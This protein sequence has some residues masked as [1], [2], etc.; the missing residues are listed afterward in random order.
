MS[1]GQHAESTNA[2]RLSMPDPANYGGRSSTE[3]V[4]AWT[5]DP[6]PAPEYPLEETAASNTVPA[7]NAT[8]TVS[9]QP[10]TATAV[11]VPTHSGPK[12]ANDDEYRY[13][14]VVPQ[15]SKLAQS[16]RR[17]NRWR[18]VLRVVALIASV[19]AFGFILGATPY[20]KRS[21]PFNNPAMVYFSYFVGAFSILVSLAFIVHSAA[22]S[23][24]RVNKIPR[25]GQIGIDTLMTLLWV[26]V[27]IVQLAKFPCPIGGHNGWCDFYN[28]SIF[29]SLL[30]M[31]IFA[32]MLGWD[33][34]GSVILA[35][36][37]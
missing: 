16:W 34:I 2:W 13:D 10:A 26:I 33:I 21:I 25:F 7:V 3:H 32:V 27:A 6:A 31:V 29:F 17:P 22:R 18:F 37:K 8:P 12:P 24:S 9:S 1:T 28:T 20:S 36:K 5:A 35:G 14:P 4:N 15:N 23:A 30:C 11:E 19:G